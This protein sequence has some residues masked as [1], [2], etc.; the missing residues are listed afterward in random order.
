MDP[1]DKRELSLVSG[2]C[3][4]D[5]LICE[6]RDSCLHD[7]TAGG[8]DSQAGLQETSYRETKDTWATKSERTKSSL[9]SEHLKVSPWKEDAKSDSGGRKE[10]IWKILLP[11]ALLQVNPVFQKQPEAT[12]HHDGMDTAKTPPGCRPSALDHDWPPVADCYGYL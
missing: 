5:I 12:G 9:E 2:S 6:R 3:Q 8:T 10:D 4:V 11:I 7:S 1:Q